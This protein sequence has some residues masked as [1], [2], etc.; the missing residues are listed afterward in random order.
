MRDFVKK[1][2]DPSLGYT[3]ER[4]HANEIQRG[5]IP[6]PIAIVAKD[7]D[8]RAV[9]R[10]VLHRT[11]RSGV[12]AHPDTP[13][14][15][16][17][18]SPEFVHVEEDH[19]RRGIASAMYALAER[20]SGLTV[21]PATYQLP[22]G[23]ALWDGN[24][25]TPQFGAGVRRLGK[26]ERERDTGQVASVAPFDL[27]GRLLFGRR[28]DSGKFTLPGGHLNPGEEPI[29][30]A[31]R[32]LLE[33]TGLRPSAISFLGSDTVAGGDGRDVTVHAF[34]AIV[35][36]EPTAAND[37]DG[38]MSTF[39]WVPMDGVPEDMLQ[40]LHAPRNVTLRLLG[41]QRWPRE[42][43]DDATLL[44]EDDQSDVPEVVVP[45]TQDEVWED[46][47]RPRRRG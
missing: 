41:L 45:L 31:V 24:E 32:E 7:R 28:A 13:A 20:E 38:E 44:G 35:N 11:L 46:A 33:E 2:L 21:I 34:M 9:G 36:G 10:A 47:Y 5:K 23:R 25:R 27:S 37:P 17:F 19:R 42:S 1:V 8:G 29:R 6:P 40:N 14:D 18:L 30:G 15:Q 26:S 12:L 22:G 4:D 39:H 3:V 43:D 16:T